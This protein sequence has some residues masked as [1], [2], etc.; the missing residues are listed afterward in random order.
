M[1]LHL[2]AADHLKLLQLVYKYIRHDE[3]R[4]HTQRYAA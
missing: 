4:C 1:K 3:L 2:T